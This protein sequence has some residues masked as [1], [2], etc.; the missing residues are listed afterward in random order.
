MSSNTAKCYECRAGEHEDEDDDIKMCVVRCPGE[1]TR[2]GNLCAAHRR[3]M[4][5]DGYEV[6][7]EEPKQ[8]A[9]V[10]TRRPDVTN[11]PKV[12]TAAW[13]DKIEAI[14]QW[15]TGWDNLADMCRNNPTL[16]I[17]ENTSDHEALAITALREA[18]KFVNGREAYPVG[19]M[20]GS[21][22]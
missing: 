15:Y 10:R 22:Y 4:E 17:T 7:V 21:G 18:Y 3:I 13:Y 2:R 12:G 9:R 14:V 16:V 6:E 8:V 5:E 1:K 20:Y 19:G 11:I